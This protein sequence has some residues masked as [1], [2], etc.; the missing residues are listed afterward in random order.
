MVNKEK[1][2]ES[3][4]ELIYAVAMADGSVQ[5]EEKN[6]LVDFLKDYSWGD[7]VL[8]SFNYEEANKQELKNA[9]DKAFSVMVEF[10]P[11]PEF[12]EFMEL[13]EKVADASDGIDDEER[14]LIDKF[15]SEIQEAFVNNPDIK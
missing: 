9:Y 2:H 12:Y 5:E 4:G 11:F 6:M 10:G 13:L 8:W 3:F 1:L 14:K 7:E 15:Q